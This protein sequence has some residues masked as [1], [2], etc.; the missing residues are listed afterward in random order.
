MRTWAR[1]PVAIL[2]GACGAV[3]QR[4]DPVQRIAIIGV[5]RAKNRGACC[6]DSEAPAD[7]PDVAEPTP[8]R[9]PIAFESIGKVAARV[10]PDWKQRQAGDD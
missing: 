10:V 2:C 9:L 8:I 4:G 7:L 5:K 6:A 1:T 3:I